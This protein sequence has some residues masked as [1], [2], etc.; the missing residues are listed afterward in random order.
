MKSYKRKTDISDL[1]YNIITRKKNFLKKEE[2]TKQRL[3]F[4]YLCGGF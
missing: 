4:V 1:H 3:I 2:K